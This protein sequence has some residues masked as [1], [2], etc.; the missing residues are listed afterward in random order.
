MA[1]PRADQSI[2]AP[3]ALIC[4]DEL[5]STDYTPYDLH[6]STI[7]T[8]LPAIT[9]VMSDASKTETGRDLP[10]LKSLWE[11]FTVDF[12]APHVSLEGRTVLVTG[13]NAG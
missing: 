9:S 8:Y 2:N 1:G 6:K 10:M 11:H 7:T 12:P 13:G 5:N 4:N 3:S